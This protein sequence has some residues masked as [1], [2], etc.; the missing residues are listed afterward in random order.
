MFNLEMAESV[1]IIEP[2]PTKEARYASATKTIVFVGGE[3]L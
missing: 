3:A 1:T 2:P